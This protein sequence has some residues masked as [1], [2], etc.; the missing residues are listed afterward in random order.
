MS[1][2][3]N[4]AKLVVQLVIEQPCFTCPFDCDCEKPKKEI[5]ANREGIVFLFGHPI[6]TMKREKFGWKSRKPGPPITKDKLRS[7][8]YGR[9]MS[10]SAEKLARKK[11]AQELWISLGR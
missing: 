8:L 10:R 5:P 4:L 11:A 6:I 7:I 1:Y 9:G 3:K 2:L